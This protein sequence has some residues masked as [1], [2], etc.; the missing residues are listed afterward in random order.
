MMRS[1]YLAVRGVCQFMPKGT[2]MSYSNNVLMGKGAVILSI[3]NRYESFEVLRANT[4]KSIM[5]KLKNK[6]GGYLIE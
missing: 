1:K 4:I 2:P 6:I 5:S 3:L